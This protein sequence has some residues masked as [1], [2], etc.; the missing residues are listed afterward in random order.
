VSKLSKH[1]VEEL[2]QRYAPVVHRRALAIVGRDS[3]A[4]DVVQEVFEKMLKSSSEF[5]AEARPMTWVYRITTNVALNALR[6]RAVREP[7]AQ[8]AAE[9]EGP[10]LAATVEARLTL[11]KA[12]NT[13]SERELQVIALTVIDGLTQDEIADVLGLSRKTINR[14]IDAI[15]QKVSAT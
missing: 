8:I 7:D 13:L 15:R 12:M 4:W 1:E 14:E 2:Y 11:R 10:E 9:P 5:R 3:D 6:A